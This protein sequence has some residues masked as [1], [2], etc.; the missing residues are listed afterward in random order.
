MGGNQKS[1]KLS[2]F[3]LRAQTLAKRLKF[4]SC[5]AHHSNYESVVARA[6]IRYAQ[7]FGNRLTWSGRL[8]FGPYSVDHF[9]SKFHTHQR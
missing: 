6:V 9:F 3:C 2:G 1:H 5:S 7:G 4:E 8:K